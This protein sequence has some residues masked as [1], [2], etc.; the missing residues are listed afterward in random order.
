MKWTGRI[1]RTHYWKIVTVMGML[2]EKS[3]KGRRKVNTRTERTRGS[4][5]DRRKGATRLVRM[6]L[7]KGNILY[8]LLLFSC[9]RLFP[10]FC[11][12]SHDSSDRIYC[13]INIDIRTLLFGK[14]SEEKIKNVKPLVVQK[15]S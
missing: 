4:T 11:S 13:T 12:S 8:K 14:Y 2:P 1:G 3:I 6:S 15:L 5:S 10:G 7:L 9:L